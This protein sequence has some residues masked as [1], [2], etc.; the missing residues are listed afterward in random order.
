MLLKNIISILIVLVIFLMQTSFFSAGVNFFSA[1]NLMVV[2]TI[3]LSYTDSK[4]S[5]SSALTGGF[6]LDLQQSLIGI[7][8]LALF[9]LINFVNLFKK[10][11]IISDRPIYFMVLA[12]FS[13]ICWL[14]MQL[15][16]VRLFNSMFNDWS[17]KGGWEFGGLFNF[18]Y[19]G[20]FIYINF[21]LLV[22]VYFLFRKKFSLGLWY[23]A[24]R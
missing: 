2:L 8:L 6:L 23:E 24:K 18:N 14:A 7:N 4:W 20:N 12:F 22:I 3:W 19:F 1:I 5:I 10:K 17:S 21:I 16:F 13:L 15:I 11:L 9:M